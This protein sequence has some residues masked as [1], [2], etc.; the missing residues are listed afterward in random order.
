MHSSQ[1]STASVSLRFTDVLELLIKFTG[2][3]VK[4]DIGSETSV[5]LDKTEVVDLVD[6][7]IF[8][9]VAPRDHFSNAGL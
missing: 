9:P 2:F 5:N 8:E 4:M 1:K 3:L 7:V 6:A